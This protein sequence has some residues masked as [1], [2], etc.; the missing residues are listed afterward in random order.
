MSFNTPTTSSP[1]T[2]YT[3]AAGTDNITATITPAGC[4]DTATSNTLTIQEGVG[5]GN[6][7][8]AME[9]V[10]YPNPVEG[11]LYIEGL[12]PGAIIILTDILGKEVYK[13]TSA[14]SKFVVNTKSLSAGT[15]ILQV[16]DSKGNRHVRHIVRR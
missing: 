2:S 9:L 13:D 7:E 1:S 6:I 16:T 12:T 5:I 8:T 15:Y 11:L 10:I 4:Y 14:N 3:K